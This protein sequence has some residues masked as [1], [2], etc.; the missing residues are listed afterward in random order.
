MEYF[1]MCSVHNRETNQRVRFPTF[2]NCYDLAI[3]FGMKEANIITTYGDNFTSI[4][5]P[6]MTI[7]NVQIFK[8]PFNQFACLDPEINYKYYMKNH[9]TTVHDPLTTAILLVQ[10]C[11]RKIYNRRFVAA[12]IIKRNIRRSIANPS[13]QLCRNRLMREFNEIK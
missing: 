3:Q 10:K 8:I 2:F 12:V 5:T 6:K 4:F 13:T 1:Y 7:L 11:W 9:I